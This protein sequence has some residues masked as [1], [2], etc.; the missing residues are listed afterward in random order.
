MSKEDETK[1]M[2]LEERAKTGY[3]HDYSVADCRKK[4]FSKEYYLCRELEKAAFC[5][6]AIQLVSGKYC[7]PRK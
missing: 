2:P 3:K 6:H 1:E 4:N 5:T 7:C